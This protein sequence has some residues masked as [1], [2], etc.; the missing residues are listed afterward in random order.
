MKK[1][2]GILGGMGPQATVDLMQKIINLTAAESDAQ[3]MRIY[4]D[5]HP[6]IPDRISAILSAA[7]DPVPAMQESLDKLT[8]MGADCVVMPCISAHYFLPQLQVKSDVC[9]INMLEVSAQAAKA[10]YPRKKCGLLCSVAT[11]KSGMVSQALSKMNVPHLHPQEEDQF[12]LGRL[13]LEVKANRT[14]QATPRFEAICQEMA[15]RGADYFLLACTELPLLAQA[16]QA[17]HRFVDATNELAKA[18][19]LNCGYELRK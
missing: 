16:Y 6:Q 1:S 2:L 10:Q 7:C 9:F 11:A 12:E 4:M 5:N 17:P 3:H 18:A 19:I 8:A 13:I 14:K 15:E